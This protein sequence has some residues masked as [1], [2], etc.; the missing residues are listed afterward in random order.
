MLPFAASK[1][2]VEVT[3]QAG[4]RGEQCAGLCGKIIRAGAA[5]LRIQIV[6]R[7]GEILKVGKK[8]FFKVRID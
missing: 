6:F 8:R 4:L 1:L 2:V 7:G 3:H 5:L